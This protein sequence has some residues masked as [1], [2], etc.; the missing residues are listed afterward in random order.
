MEL[1]ERDGQ[2]AVLRLLLDEGVTG[3]G[4]V[5]VLCGPV[6]SGRTEVLRRLR[7]D[8]E[9]A[10]VVVLGAVGS[11][12]ERSLPMGVLGQLVRSAGLTARYQRLLAGRRAPHTEPA[13]LGGDCDDRRPPVDPGLAG[14]VCELL[15]DH[16]GDR[17]ALVLVD[18]LQHADDA[19]LQTLLHL[20]RRIASTRM[21]VVLGVVTRTGGPLASFHAQLNR[22][23]RCH[24][25][26]IGMLT[27]TG[28]AELARRR[29]GTEPSPGLVA[30]YRRASGGNPLLLNA[31]IEDTG[32]GRDEVVAGE[33]YREAVAACLYRGGCRALWVGRALAVLNPAD[34]VALV[35][36]IIDSTGPEDLAQA[37][38]GMAASG[39]VDA[40]GRFRHP[41]ARTAVR[42]TLSAT[43]AATLHARA[44]T[45]LYQDGAEPL[46]VAEHLL[47]AGE[48]TEEWTVDVLVRAG[49][50]A[51]REDRV[52]LASSCLERAFHAE[53]GGRLRA[54]VLTTLLKVRWRTNPAATESLLGPLQ[55]SLRAG[56]LLDHEVGAVL[57]CLAWHARFAEA[58]ELV[59]HLESIVDERGGELA[60]VVGAARLWLRHSHR[61][62][63]VTAPPDY[64]VPVGD[65]GL[66][67]ATALAASLTRGGG[68]RARS[69]AEYVLQSSL[70][71]EPSIEAVFSALLA[72]VYADDLD[73]AA[74]W[75]AKLTEQALARRM[76]ALR[77]I[78]LGVAADVAA[79]RGNLALA[80]RTAVE[81]LEVISERSW[82]VAVAYPLGTLITAT[83]A[84]GRFAD[85]ERLLRNPL[86]EPVSATGFWLHYLDA[87]GHYAL[88]TGRPH[89]ALE[90]FRRC[91][92]LMGDWGVDV[93]TLI[94]WRINAGKAYL[95]LGRTAE[96]K[97]M[98]EVQSKPVRG[99]PPT[100]RG[101]SL[102]LLADISDTRGRTA[103]LKESVQLLE[104]S[105]HHLELTRALA[106]QSNEHY[107]QGDSKRSRALARRA[108]QV[109]RLCDAEE[110]GRSLLVAETSSYVDI[111]LPCAAELSEAERKVATL[112]ANGLTNRQ[113]GRELYLS[114]STVEQHL[115]R[116]YR[117]LDVGKRSQLIELVRQRSLT[118]G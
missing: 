81:A 102:R 72:L 11:W 68:E 33:A 95:A 67:A 82:G 37:L 25:V 56:H 115:T 108:I 117:K 23:R 104:E 73:Q 112:A 7:A 99:E 66:H 110:A 30:D 79:R 14:D 71:D 114:V 6:T 75:C 15:L 53:V 74:A 51:L 1:V 69:S 65:V 12:A 64:P 97:A 9:R 28:I 18:D 27:D 3:G 70:F 31:L 38:A 88:A 52:E 62:L 40:D 26:E 39:L 19:S 80:R 113:I 85:A 106:A 24:W 84:L 49:A 29:T 21:L 83:T 92:K 42:E 4:E 87:R 118:P 91:G 58:L 101:V 78:V 98:F 50:D 93:S 89:A 109:A 55:E 57:R 45:A 116:I 32:P 60:S 13:P 2:L 35:H 86:P 41:A 105:G 5:A 44:A 96:A 63:A 54:A 8:A 76:P 47:L 20:Q 22:H 16:V 94:P 61:G 17:R 43:A 10:G 77:G 90:D 46:A 107:A 48:A 36:R 59:R 111:R 103:L 34:P 100:M